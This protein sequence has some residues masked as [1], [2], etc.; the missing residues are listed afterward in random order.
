MNFDSVIGYFANSYLYDAPATP[1]VEIAM[2][3]SGMAIAAIVPALFFNFA[4]KGGKHAT[5]LG[6][7]TVVSFIG[8]FLA[9]L[10]VASYPMRWNAQFK[11]CQ[12]IEVQVDYKGTAIPLLA[13]ECKTR[14]SLDAE[15]SDWQFDSVA[16][17]SAE[18]KH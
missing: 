3:F 12:E 1:Y 2:L 14:N 8:C 15:W 10:L 16:V 4:L 11:E 13:L 6:M 7:A 5:V 9:G 18:K 17:E